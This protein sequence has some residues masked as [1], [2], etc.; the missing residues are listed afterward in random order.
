MKWFTKSIHKD[1]RIKNSF[2]SVGIGLSY[3]PLEDV[4]KRCWFRFGMSDMNL[5]FNY[6]KFKF[7]LLDIHILW[8]HNVKQFMDNVKP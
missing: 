3:T 8:E 6:F 2:Y 4:D 5:N 7:L 1:F